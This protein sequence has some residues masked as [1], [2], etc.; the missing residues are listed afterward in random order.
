[1]A[2]RY[3]VVCYRFE[4]ASIKKFGFFL[5]ASHVKRLTRPCCAA[6][7]RI[8]FCFE[9]LVSRTLPALTFQDLLLLSSSTLETNNSSTSFSSSS[10]RTSPCQ[11]LKTR[12]LWAKLASRNPWFPL[13][14]VKEI[15]K[16]VL[17]SDSR[18]PKS[19][20]DARHGASHFLVLC[21]CGLCLEWKTLHYTRDRCILSMPIFA[22]SIKILRLIWIWCFSKWVI[23][24]SSVAL[25]SAT[26]TCMTN[27]LQNTPCQVWRKKAIV[28]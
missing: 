11:I 9:T 14:W 17:E 10:K 6:A 3:S 4:P 8:S 12:S 21:F 20:L 2:G 24:L 13:G 28:S 22:P 15:K 19:G 26:S 27:A 5:V 25:E 7:E 16:S 18:S 1:M 23:L